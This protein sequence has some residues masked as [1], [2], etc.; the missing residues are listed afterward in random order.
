M[1]WLCWLW[2][3]SGAALVLGWCRYGARNFVDV[4]V[5]VLLESE[6]LN[7]G[8][9]LR[10]IA[11]DEPAAL[12][13]VEQWDS[14]AVVVGQYLRLDALRSVLHAPFTVGVAPQA[15]EQQPGQRVALG[16]QLVGEC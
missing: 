3:N 1:P 8:N 12:K 9:A 5:L 11:Q 13:L 6:Y 15:D 14:I 7:V 2:C 4:R 10:L 16:E